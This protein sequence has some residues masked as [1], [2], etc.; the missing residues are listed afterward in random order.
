MDKGVDFFGSWHFPEQE[1]PVAVVGQCKDHAKKAGPGEVRE[2]SSV[3]GA[4]ALGLLVTSQ[5]FTRECRA[6]ASAGL[7]HD[8]CLLLLQLD[9]ASG[10]LLAAHANASLRKRFGSLTVGSVLGNGL[11]RPVVMW[12]TI[13]LS[14][15]AD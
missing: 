12:D 2:F 7:A 1:E 9:A 6:A 13:V 14:T 11:R 4:D 10:A 15:E 3:V 8:P 5:G